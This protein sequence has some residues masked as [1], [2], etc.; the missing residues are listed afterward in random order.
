MTAQPQG[1]LSHPHSTEED[2]QAWEFLTPNM[3][4]EDHQGGL[5]SLPDQMEVLLT[6]PGKPSTTSKGG[7]GVNGEQ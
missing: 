6:T 3:A 5:V 1:V 2:D 4:T 7:G